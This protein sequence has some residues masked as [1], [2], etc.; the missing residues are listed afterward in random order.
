MLWL[1]YPQFLYRSLW[2]KA[3]H[4]KVQLGWKVFRLARFQP[5]LIEVNLEGKQSTNF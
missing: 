1:L 5:K 2:V 3:S 4:I